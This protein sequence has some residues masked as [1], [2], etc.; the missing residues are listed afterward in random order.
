MNISPTENEIKYIREALY[1]F[2]NERVGKD[3]HTYTTRKIAT[4]K[5]MNGENGNVL[6]ISRKMKCCEKIAFFLRCNTFVTPRV[7]Q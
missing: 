6:Q 7:L 2:N 5:A 1:Q 4:P 3:S